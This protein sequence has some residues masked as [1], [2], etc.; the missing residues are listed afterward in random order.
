MT[1]FEQESTEWSEQ[2][3]YTKLRDYAAQE[4]AAIDGVDGGEGE[5]EEYYDEEEPAEGEQAE[6]EQ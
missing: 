2:E 6:A 3:Q 4:I 5:E 1:L